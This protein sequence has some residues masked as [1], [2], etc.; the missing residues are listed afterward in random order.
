MGLC[1]C[2]PPPGAFLPAGGAGL[3]PG[4]LG[5]ALPLWGCKP[6]GFAEDNGFLSLWASVACTSQ[7]G[8]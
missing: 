2:Q 6:T 7:A 5:G 4:R 8:M 1:G 3:P